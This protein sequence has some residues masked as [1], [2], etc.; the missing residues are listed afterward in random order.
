MRT[1]S[2]FTNRINVPLVGTGWQTYNVVALG[3]D[4]AAKLV[5][6]ELETTIGTRHVGVRAVGASSSSLYLFD[7]LGADTVTLTVP[8]VSGAI[9]VYRGPTADGLRASVVAEW[10]GDAV[11]V[12][13][14]DPGFTTGLT[15]GNSE[16]YRPFDL[17]SAV[18]FP[19]VP[20]DAGGIAAV[21]C[22][23]IPS[24]SGG[25]L[26]ADARAT[27][28]SWN[29]PA[30]VAAQL[31]NTIV[32]VD[33]GDDLEVRESLT[34][35]GNA[36]DSF[37]YLVAYIKAGPFDDGTGSFYEWVSKQTPVRDTLNSSSFTTFSM[38]SFVDADA[39]AIYYRARNEST[40]AADN[41]PFGA[42]QIG[43]TN[44]TT[45]KR[46]NSGNW[47][48]AFPEL[49]GAS[50]QIQIWKNQAKIGAYTFGWLNFSGEVPRVPVIVEPSDGS[51][52]VEEEPTMRI[53]DNG[54]NQP[55]AADEFDVYFGTSPTPPL[56]A[57]NVPSGG[58]STFQA[59]GTLSPLTTYYQRVVAKNAV[60]EA[61][62]LVE[63]WTTGGPPLK[64]IN[65]TPVDGAVDLEPDLP[66]IADISWD[67]VPFDPV[68]DADVYFGLTN[69]PPLYL[70]NYSPEVFTAPIPLQLDA[71]YYWRV[72]PT[73]SWGQTTGDLWSFTIKSLK[74]LAA[75]PSVFPRVLALTTSGRRVAASITNLMRVDALP[76]T[77]T[78]IG[79]E[80]SA[81]PRISAVASVC[82]TGENM[83]ANAL[84]P[85]ALAWNSTNVLDLSDVVDDLTDPATAITSAVSVV[86]NI[87]DID[88]DELLG[89][90]P[91]ALLQVGG[92]N[93]WQ[94]T[95]DVTE[96]NGFHRGQ[97]I[98]VEFTFDGGADLLGTFEALGQV[99]GA[100]N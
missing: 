57:S 44:P 9:Q 83:T 62:T 55:D 26:E 70:P 28:S 92:T 23:L 91:I 93:H 38:S 7:L 46:W 72:D 19:I 66:P 81:R 100:S 39:V 21:I 75:E 2:G 68:D 20:G 25:G 82:N 24:A 42:R 22:L 67:Y 69:P 15:L 94:A 53:A 1:V 99:A 34:G 10:G 14:S 6:V 95:V 37:V 78:R 65:P 40:T 80:P 43:S 54:W 33:G 27:G 96:A 60:G 97:R 49:T 5:T 11:V 48:A 61:T 64:A 3:V 98:R 16:T 41:W 88:A 12:P 79:A 36:Q 30:V 59:L 77:G 17:K 73:N 32:A 87:F 84:C 86:A 51:V 90:S 29:Q 35:K 56:F 8:V 63:S 76:T 71:T 47:S 74:C 50:K 4:P 45:I 58:A 31:S 18:G 89:V 85:D 52:N 13:A